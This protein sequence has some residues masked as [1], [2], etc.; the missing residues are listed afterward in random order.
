MGT[1]QVDSDCAWTEPTGP[2]DPL[3]GRG[4]KAKWRDSFNFIWLSTESSRMVGQ[5]WV[6]IFSPTKCA[7]HSLHMRQCASQNKTKTKQGEIWCKSWRVATLLTFKYPLN[8]FLIWVSTGKVVVWP[9]LLRSKLPMFQD[10][11]GIY[12]ANLNA[13]IVPVKSTP[14]SAKPLQKYLQ[15]EQVNSLM[16]C[17]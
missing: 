14:K 12:L 10:I 1:Q 11:R 15:V 9:Q 13:A 6:L 16:H 4:R 2:L 5:L 7:S 3:S 17:W 8:Q